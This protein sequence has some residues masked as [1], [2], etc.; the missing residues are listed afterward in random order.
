MIQV[1]TGEGKGK[2]T[3]ALG[4]ALRA[5]GAGMKVYIGQFIKGR[6]YSEIKALKKIPHIKIEQF[7][8]GCFIRKKPGKADIEMAGSGLNRVREII[9]GGKYKVIILDEINVA[10]KLQL[11]PLSGLLEL[12][13]IVPAGTELVLTGRDAH[14]SVIRMADL[15]SRIKEVKHYFTRGIKARRGIEF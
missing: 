10:L 8:R 6:F 1:Y 12:M 9:A 13:K 11:L 14:P 7:G 2:T 3:A 5:S 15:V 4:L